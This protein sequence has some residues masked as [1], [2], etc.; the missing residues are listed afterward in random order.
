MEAR[1]MITPSIFRLVYRNIRVNVDPG[2]MII[3]IGIPALYLVFFGLGVQSM[4]STF[5]PEN[6]GYLAFLTPGIMGFQAVTA[7]L[8][9]GSMLWADRRYGMLAQLLVGPFSRLQYLFGI[10]IT[11]TVFGIAGAAVMLL[12][13]YLLIGSLQVTMTGIIVVFSIIGVGSILFGSLMLLISAYVRSNNAYTGIQVLIVFVVNF[14]ST[15]FYPLGNNL[16]LGMRMLF[17]MNP[18]TYVVNLARDAFVGLVPV[19]DLY[20]IPLLCIETIVMIALATRAYIRSEV[21]FE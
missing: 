19:A 7:G 15:V 4:M 5:S 9:G 1:R 3:L 11:S 12:G 13:A 21:S 14:A 20:Q 18:L 10:I 8:V 6:G 16:P 2:N 17:M